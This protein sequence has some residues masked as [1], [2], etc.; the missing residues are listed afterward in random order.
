MLK[1]IVITGIGIIA[2]IGIG[3]TEFWRNLLAGKSGVGRVQSFETSAYSVHLGAE[4]K[5]FDPARYI[6]SVDTDELGRSSQL[7]IAATRLA[8]ED[9]GLNSDDMPKA[10][11]GVALGTTMGES[12]VLEKI[13]DQWV[14]SGADAI[15]PALMPRYP[16]NVIPSNVAIEF[17]FKGA[18]IMIPT[19][20]AAGNYAIGYATDLLKQNRAEVMI[21]G[22]ADCFSRIAFTGFARLGAIAPDICQPF[23]KN[24]K[25][26]MLGEGAG[27]LILEPLE[28]A[29][30]RKATIY[31]EVLGYGLSCDAYHMTGGHPE[32]LGLASAMDKAFRR[33]GIVPQDV[34]YI[35]A[36]G[37]GTPSNDRIE[38]LAI[39]KALG[40]HAYKVPVS[41]IKSMIGHTM[42]AASAVEAAVC[43]LSIQNNIIPPTIN[44]EEEDAECDLNY[45][46]NQA[47]KCPVEVAVNNS[48]A[49]GGNNAVLVLG[50]H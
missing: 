27:I 7:A 41:S 21:A 40:E 5:G 17:G 20:C 16:S 42:G 30:Q 39:K 24:R 6:Q 28:R 36:H 14:E 2:P 49:F 37:T 18:N 50:H 33:S 22:G 13:N 4:I 32:G 38:T 34:S 44:Y 15:Q 19:A 48:A 23:D 10:R 46:P 25:G 26:M 1:R 11:V 45:V 29:M 3:K 8:L 47:R 12:Q 43:A 31:A 9:A 35:S